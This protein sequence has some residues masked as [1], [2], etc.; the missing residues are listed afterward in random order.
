MIAK[1]VSLY[2]FILITKILQ[3]GTCAWQQSIYKAK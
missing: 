3:I 2:S 1:A